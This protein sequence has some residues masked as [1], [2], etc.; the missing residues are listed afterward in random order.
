[1]TSAPDSGAQCTWHL[2]RH[3]GDVHMTSSS[4]SGW[5]CTWPLPPTRGWHCKRPL[6]LTCRW[7]CKWPLPL[8]QPKKVTFSVTTAQHTG[9]STHNL[10]LRPGGAVHMTFASDDG[11]SAHDIYQQLSGAVHMTSTHDSE[12]HWSDYH[13]IRVTMQEVTE[14]I[15]SAP[16]AGGVEHRTFAS[17]S[18]V[19]MHMT[20]ACNSGVQ[21][22]DFWF[23]LE[24]DCAS[25]I[26][27]EL[28]GDRA[29]DLCSTLV[30]NPHKKH[31]LSALKFVGVHMNTSFFF[32]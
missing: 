32:C 23:W 16:N 11:D 6:P 27:P 1:M 7:K 25:D 26:C 31:P 22:I 5:N 9:D 2:P 3:Q 21:C 8:S 14:H 17:D 30:E 29:S 20:S 19:T 10:C 15:T 4:T 28:V 18:R 24:G 13:Q 12:V